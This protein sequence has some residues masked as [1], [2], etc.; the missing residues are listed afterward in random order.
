[1]AS[2]PN[3]IF[4]DLGQTS[5]CTKFLCTSLMKQLCKISK[6]CDEIQPQL[7][8]LLKKKKSIKNK[9]K[10]ASKRKWTQIMISNQ[11]RNP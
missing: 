1:M 8:Q 5:M 6:M 9:L 2:E 11:E 3:F 7:L 10:I 4:S